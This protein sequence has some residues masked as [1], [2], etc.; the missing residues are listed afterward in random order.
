MDCSVIPFCPL[1]SLTML[2]RTKESQVS[3]QRKT[4]YVSTNITAEAREALTST[5]LQLSAKAGKRVPQSA[6]LIAAM[7]IANEHPDQLEQLVGI[8]EGENQ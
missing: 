6:V 2:T 7:Q 1:Q 8:R 5:T 4:P 3:A